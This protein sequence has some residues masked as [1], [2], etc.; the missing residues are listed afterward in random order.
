LESGG[1]DMNLRQKYKKAKQKLDMYE[2]NVNTK[3]INLDV[4]HHPVV[5]IR[6]VRRIERHRSDISASSIYYEQREMVRILEKTAGK[7]VVFDVYDDEYTGDKVIEGDLY[8][9]DMKG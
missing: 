6:T 1:L 9:V 7:Y 4:Q 5:P 3:P 8:L 2:K